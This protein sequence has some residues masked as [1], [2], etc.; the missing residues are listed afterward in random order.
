MKTLEFLRKNREE[1]YKI[2]E[3]YG[4]SNIRVFGSVACGKENKKS[5]VDLLV[6]VYDYKKYR[7]GGWLRNFFQI[8]VEQLVKRRVDVATEKN[9]KPFAKKYIL[10]D[11]VKL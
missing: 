5:D 2:A 6:D 9:I 8:E 3:K 10:A 4:V 1:I 7:I 11:V